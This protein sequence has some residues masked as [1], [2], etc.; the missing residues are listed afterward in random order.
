MMPQITWFVHD[1]LLLFSAI[2][3]VDNKAIFIFQIVIFRQVTEL[4]EGPEIEL[5][6]A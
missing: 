1:V 5:T 2:K 6:F 3:L 4:Y